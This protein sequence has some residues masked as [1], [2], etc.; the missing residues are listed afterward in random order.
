MIDDERCDALT[1]WTI[2]GFVS[3]RKAY[4]QPIDLETL[5]RCTRQ[6]GHDGEHRHRSV[7]AWRGEWVAGWI[8][9]RGDDT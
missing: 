8:D 5:L 6:L 7:R 9:E 4:A 1:E 3:K 2:R